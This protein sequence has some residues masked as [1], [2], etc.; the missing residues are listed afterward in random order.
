MGPNGIL[1]QQL[2]GGTLNTLAPNASQE[3][4]ITSLNDIIRRLNLQL[5]TQAF[6]DDTSKRYINGFLA[7]GWPGGDFGMKISAPGYDV[8]D[9]NAVLL[10]SWDYTTNQQVIYN[11]NIPTILIGSA[12][13]DGR[14]GIWLTI[15]GKDV[16]NEL[17]S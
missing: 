6:S 12:P 2:N 15:P 16:L 5:K 7:G 11:E 4:V 14:S 3:D 13:G 1:G 8:T 17:S 9:P 10:F